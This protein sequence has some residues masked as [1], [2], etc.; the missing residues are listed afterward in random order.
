MLLLGNDIV[1]LNEA[2]ITGDLS[3][4][5]GVLHV[6]EGRSKES[7]DEFFLQLSEKQRQSIKAICMDMWT[8]ISKSKVSMSQYHTL[9]VSSTG[10]ISR[11]VLMTA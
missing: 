3:T 5:T 2:G 11:N 10:S 8:R 6:C 7:L 1:D 4:K 9:R